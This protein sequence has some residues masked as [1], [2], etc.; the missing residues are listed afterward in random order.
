[1]RNIFNK[2]FRSNLSKQLRD[3]KEQLKKAMNVATGLPR[4]YMDGR[5]NQIDMVLKKLK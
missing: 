4:S 5:V 3:E 2:R 1:M